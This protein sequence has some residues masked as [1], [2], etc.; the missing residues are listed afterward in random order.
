MLGSVLL[1]LLVAPGRALD[2]GT[3]LR[4]VL[5]DPPMQVADFAAVAIGLVVVLWFC[6]MVSRARYA[7]SSSPQSAAC[8]C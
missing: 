1:G 8:C 6:G 4:R 3:A 2:Q 5:A 7:R